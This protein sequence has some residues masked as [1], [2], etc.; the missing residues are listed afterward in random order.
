MG[1]NFARWA[2]DLTRGSSLAV[3]AN[4]IKLALHAPEEPE[5]RFTVTEE[6]LHQL[7]CLNPVD[8]IQIDDGAKSTGFP[9]WRMMFN[10]QFHLGLELVGVSPRE[11]SF[12]FILPKRYFDDVCNATN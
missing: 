1:L 9:L 6:F 11:H 10:V 2:F 7:W 3:R 8:G 5:A 12:T 4:A